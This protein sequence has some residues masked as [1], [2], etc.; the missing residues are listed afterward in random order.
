MAFTDNKLSLSR[1]QKEPLQLLSVLNGAVP[2][3]G[4]I[5]DTEDKGKCAVALLAAVPAYSNLERTIKK[6]SAIQDSSPETSGS[7]NALEEAKNT[8]ALFERLYGNAETGVSGLSHGRKI[9]DNVYLQDVI[10][11]LKNETKKSKNQEDDDGL[12]KKWTKTVPILRICTDGIKTALMEA[13]NL[14]NDTKNHKDK[15]AYFE[16]YISADE[17]PYIVLPGA[18]KHDKKKKKKLKSFKYSLGVIVRKKINKKIDEN[19]D[20][21][22]CVVAETG[23][24]RIEAG[25]LVREKTNIK[26]SNSERDRL[27][28]NT[29]GEVS[30]YA[31][32]ILKGLDV[33]SIDTTDR[34]S[35]DKYND[36]EGY[37][38]GN[39][40]VEKPGVEYKI[41]IFQ[42]SA[43]VSNGH[44]GGWCYKHHHKE[45]EED[46]EKDYEENAKIFRQDIVNQGEKILKT[47]NEKHPETK[48]TGNCLNLEKPTNKKTANE[49]T[50]DK[51]PT[52]KKALKKITAFILLAL[53]LA[54][55]QKP[56]TKEAESIAVNKETVQPAITVPEKQEPV[57]A[58]EKKLSEIYDWENAR[59]LDYEYFP[60]FGEGQ[61][62]QNQDY[63]FYPEDGC[64]IARIDKVDESKK[65][66]CRFS[67]DTGH[68]HYCFSDDGLLIENN[69]NVY[70]CGFDGKNLHKIISRKKLKKRVTAI[71]P[72]AWWYGNYKVLKFHQ[73]SLYLLVGSFI[74]KL[75]LKTKKTTK[76]SKKFFK[77][78]FCGSTLYYT[79]TR[80]SLYKTDLRTGKN[81]LVTKKKCDALAETDGELYYVHNLNIYMY[82]KGKK[83]KKIFSFEKKIK[84]FKLYDINSDSGKIAATYTTDDYEKSVAIYDTRTSAFSKIENI[85]DIAYLRYF[86][87]DMLFYSTAYD[88]EEEY[89]SYLSYPQPARDKTFKIT[90]ESITQPG[91]T[92]YTPQESQ[93]E[94]LSDKYDWD[95]AKITND[96][97]KD[98]IPNLGNGP[99]LQNGNYIFYP[100]DGCRIIRIN[101]KDKTIKLVCQF[102][103]AKKKHST[104]GI[105]FCLSDSRLF[106]SYAGS[107]YS[108]GFEGEDFHKIISRKKLKK[109]TGLSDV[110]A[111]RFHKG[112]LY[113]PFDEWSIYRLDLE[114]KKAT[115]TSDHCN[116]F[117]GYLCGNALYYTEYIYDTLY[118]VD[119][120]NIHTGRHTLIADAGDYAVTESDG[121]LYYLESGLW[122]KVTIYMYRKGKKDKKIWESDIEVSETYC[123]PGKIAMQYCNS[124]SSQK[125]GFRY[126]NV[127]IYDIKTSTIT[128]I[129][130]IPDFY[131]IAGLSGDMLFYIKNQDD[132]YLSYIAY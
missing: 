77:A 73:G 119:I 48:I 45:G 11:S 68:I 129:E 32:W 108:C 79:G 22:F 12:G 128:K 27:V 130:N 41:I 76:M 90:R 123:T 69:G 3:T 20:Y 126:N 125:Y 87:G 101:K 38:I 117:A 85:E 29:L 34:N 72:G 25:N 31:A 61:V 35:L 5:T 107:I 105:H 19:D 84:I 4:K 39:N 114:T 99:V 98:N 100:E 113:L 92:E 103:S 127:L 116:I 94:K 93:E 33:S 58:K 57:Q 10:T 88:D 74:W 104:T 21:L 44:R 62:L 121:K 53:L 63:V 30:I 112:S 17:I 9:K 1:K 71:E 80:N 43:P 78:C 15:T 67:P 95:S 96:Y 50:T 37:N 66:I 51:K 55:C 120:H 7:M 81:S 118:K 109:L 131:S 132:K 65:I 54:G 56:A 16:D 2:V 47:Y 102:D 24:A 13:N 28:K 97:D 26:M 60:D 23:P 106:I 124:N 91:G 64:K 86:A 8:A 36:N 75:N 89:I 111:M 6:L 110:Y 59:I 14:Y 70:S 52:I 82:C 83:D 122:E 46:H 18:K 115:Q 40:S 49:K 42:T